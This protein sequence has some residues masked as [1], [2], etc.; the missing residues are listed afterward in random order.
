M[1]ASFSSSV[2]GLLPL[3]PFTDWIEYLSNVPYLGYINWFI[4]MGT[5]VKITASWIG[6]I[7][8]YYIY[9][10]ILRWIKMVQ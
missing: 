1:W 7:A 4:P 8:V 9:S 5:M 6:A 3:S 10:V 2:L